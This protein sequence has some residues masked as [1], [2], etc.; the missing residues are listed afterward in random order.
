MAI[1]SMY[2][3]MSRSGELPA[4]EAAP[5]PSLNATTWQPA[6]VV[7]RV[8]IQPHTG[9]ETI[10]DSALGALSQGQAPAE[11]VNDPAGAD[12][13]LLVGPVAWACE[14]V[15]RYRH[16]GRCFPIVTATEGEREN[17]LLLLDAGADDYV[18]LPLDT[19]EL[20]ARVHAL[21]RRSYP[22][23]WASEVAIDPRTQLV[24]VGDLV[25]RLARKPFCIF[26]YL[27][28]RRDRWVSAAEIITTVCG[29]HH[30]NDTS[31]VR[32]HVHAIR[33]ALGERRSCIR[34]DASGRGYM[35]SLQ[36]GLT[37]RLTHA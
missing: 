26:V 17:G 35:F 32:V 2:P 36:G 24:R 25:V 23:S 34:G 19:H 14:E 8:S 22:G 31:L 16:A 4:H 13:V 15:Q 20:R 21:L 33:A 3:T 12:L 29:T 27:V 9:F 10:A 5:H 6:Q 18:P 30:R 1:Q 7:W 11:H 28:E 37:P